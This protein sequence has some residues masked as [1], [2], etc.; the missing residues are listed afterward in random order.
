MAGLG[1]FPDQ[2]LHDEGPRRLKC[3]AA[4]VAAER[5]GVELG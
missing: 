3:V 2:A 1:S 4:L 5:Y